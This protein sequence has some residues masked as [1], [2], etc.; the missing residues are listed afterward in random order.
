MYLTFSVKFLISCR[1]LNSFPIS[2]LIP[3]DSNSF[4]HQPYFEFATVSS[5][6][7]SPMM[8][9]LHHHDLLLSCPT[10]VDHGLYLFENTGLYCGIMMPACRKVPYC[11]KRKKGNGKT[12]YR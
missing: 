8:S 1:S 5:F 6:V 3:R 11:F 4:S 2:I 9:H 10:V 7:F 12:N